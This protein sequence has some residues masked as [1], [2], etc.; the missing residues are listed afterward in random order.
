MIGLGLVA[1]DAQLEEYVATL[2][3][4]GIWGGLIFEAYRFALSKSPFAR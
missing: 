1:P 4:F 2:A 3:F